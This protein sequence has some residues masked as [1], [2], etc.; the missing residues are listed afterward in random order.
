LHVTWL[1]NKVDIE[2]AVHHGFKVVVYAV[3]TCH[4]VA[5]SGIDLDL[6]ANT[7]FADAPM[8]I[9]DGLSDYAMIRFELSTFIV[10]DSK[11]MSH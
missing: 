1:L 10:V 5:S 6:D 9:T 4:A 7:R 11:C 2:F 8:L 3:P